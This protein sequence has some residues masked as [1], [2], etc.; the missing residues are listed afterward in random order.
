M[1]KNLCDI[2]FSTYDL[3]L[4]FVCELVM[5]WILIFLCFGGLRSLIGGSRK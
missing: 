3:S 1:L 2:F 5:F 4:E